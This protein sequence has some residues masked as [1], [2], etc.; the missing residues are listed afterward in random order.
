MQV[1]AIISEY[2]PFHY[3]HFYQITRT[4]ELLPDAAVVAFMSGNYVQRGDIA[5]WEKYTRARLAVQSGGPDLVLELPLTAALSSAEGFAQGAAAQIQAAGCI[6]H[7]S[8]GSECGSAELLIRAAA[9]TETE[10]F[11]QMRKCAMD[12]G[13]PYPAALHQA[14]M[15]VDPDCA[16]VFAQP[17]DTL[18]LEYCRALRLYAK[19]VQPIAIRRT[20]AAHDSS[21]TAQRIC[22]ASHL[23]TLLDQKTS[24]ARE[25]LPPPADQILNLQRL[26]RIHEMEAAILPYLRRL[27]PEYLASVHGIS[28]GLEY[29]FAEAAAKAQS[30][31]QLYEGMKSKRYPLSRIRRAVLCAYLGITSELAARGPQY[32]RVLAMNQRGREV[33]RRMKTTCSLPV[34]TKPT[35]ARALTG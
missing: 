1:C 23:R 15:A 14:A 8:F 5:V 18:G 13:L 17:N 3:G 24:C 2:N 11:C 26:H 30:L 9:L 21:E 19:N 33:L 6:T 12:E 35:A 10:A 20:G 22:S 32:I 16:D 28:E 31:P 4:R 34:I 7:L 25:F 27:S 29:R